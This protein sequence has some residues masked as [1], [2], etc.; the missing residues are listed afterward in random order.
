MSSIIDEYL[1]GRQAARDGKSIPTNASRHFLDG[2]RART[3]DAAVS[4]AG[5]DYKQ[6]R[7]D[8][9]TL[10]AVVKGL[11]AQKLVADP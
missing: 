10:V 4:R 5:W 1:A 6:R 8:A 11:P 3:H 2:F 7:I 9:D